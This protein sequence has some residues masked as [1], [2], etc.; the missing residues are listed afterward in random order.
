MLRHV[1]LALLLLLPLPAAAQER[2]ITLA[3]TTSAKDSGLLGH[4]IPLFRE[5]ADL[6]VRVVALGTGRALQLGMRGEADALLVHDR[7]GENRFVAEGH[8]VDH[9]EVMVNDYIIVGP[10]TDP[11]RVRSVTR[12][13]EAFRLIAQEKQPFVSR[14]D[15]SG[16]H[17]MELR[18]WRAAGLGTPTG[19]WYQTIGRGMDRSL[20]I[21][22]GL[23][24]YTLT[25]RATWAHFQNRNILGALLRGDPALL[26]IYS[27]ILVNPSKGAHIKAEDAKVW[28]NWITSEAGQRAIASFRVSEEQPFHPIGAMPVR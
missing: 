6:D 16:T 10:L 14:G 11:A 12:A 2:F 9:R 8:G 4:L 13:H 20:H 15:D 25:D 28:H 26:N 7:D 24:A 5:H 1:V 22:A 19:A 17:R 18:L 21:V 27:S 3:A 23:S